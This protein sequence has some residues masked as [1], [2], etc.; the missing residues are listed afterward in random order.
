MAI[1]YEHIRNDTNEVFYVGIGVNEYRAYEIHNRNKHWKN[2]VNKVGYT[3]N[4]IHNNI[5]YTDA[6]EIEK[7][8][9]SKYGRRDLGLGN[10]VNMTYGGDG[11]LGRNV[12]EETRHKLSEAGRGK[13]HSE[14]TRHKLSEAHKNKK[15]AK[16]YYYMK[17]INKYQANI[18][19]LGQKQIYLGIFK[20]EEEAAKA[21]QDAKLIY[22]S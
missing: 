4:I 1:V 14:E 3:I 11:A 20:T 17:S 10:L 9:I 8:L 2:I 15:G 16:G 7:S 13:T 5:D 18:R 22:H 12:S 6:C 19:V 21:Y